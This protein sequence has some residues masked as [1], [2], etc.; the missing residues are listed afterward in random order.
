M[1]TQNIFSLLTLIL[2]GIAFY[3]QWPKFSSWLERKE[4]VK[5]SQAS[6]PDKTIKET[7]EPTSTRVG[8]EIQSDPTSP[9]SENKSKVVNSVK[10]PGKKTRPKRR[11]S[12]TFQPAQRDMRK[13]ETV[14]QASKIS[15]SITNGFT[16]DNSS[17]GGSW[18]G[19]SGHLSGKRPTHIVKIP[20]Y[21]GQNQLYGRLKLGTHSNKYYDFA[22]D[23][24]EAPHP[25]LYFDLNQNGDLTDDGNPLHNQGS[26]IFATEIKLPVRRLIKELDLPG[27]FRIWFFTNNSLWKKSKVSHYSRTRMKGSLTIDGKTYPAYLAEWMVNDADFTNDGIYIDLD[28]NGKIERRS[29]FIKPGDVFQVNGK[30][31]I[32]EIHW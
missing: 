20:S 22:F 1:K 12:L 27:D 4:S 32:C 23:L 5:Q 21:Q 3:I 6:R 25:V 9:T 29:E 2:L 28:G 14:K 30:K 13:R 26:G 8:R 31:Y 11:A 15:V 17:I 19:F 24:I 18:S 16:P 10:R 7:A